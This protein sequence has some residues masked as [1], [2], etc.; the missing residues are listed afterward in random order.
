MRK[1]LK[2]SKKKDKTSQWIVGGILAFVLFGSIFGIVVDSITS[3]PTEQKI[4]YKGETFNLINGRYYLFLGDYQFSFA[5]NPNELEEVNINLTKKINSF[6]DL[7]LYIDS[8]DISART[9][10]YINLDSFAQRIQLACF[11]EEDCNSELPLKT[12]QDNLIIIRNSTQNKIY[13]QENCIFIE[14]ED[15]NK[16]AD[17]LILSLIGF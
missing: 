14:G 17:K 15:L 8:K 7:P 11:N 5:N 4:T 13:E 6:T 12:C 16:L 9:E 2:K 10:I 3:K 1:P